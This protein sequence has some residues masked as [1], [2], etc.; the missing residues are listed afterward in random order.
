M[1]YTLH[2][3][4]VQMFNVHSNIIESNKNSAQYYV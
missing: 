4:I 1:Q 3:A 2:Y